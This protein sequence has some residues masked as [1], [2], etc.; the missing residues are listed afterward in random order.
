MVWF[1]F[2]FCLGCLS[3]AVIGTL[4]ASFLLYSFA[5]ILALFLRKLFLK[6]SYKP[7]N[8]Q[9]SASNNTQYERRY[10]YGIQ[11]FIRSYYDLW[12]R[13]IFRHT[14]DSGTKSDMNK[15]G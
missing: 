2:I 3:F 4:L 12:R 10:A 15:E 5:Y 7:L 13:D 8:E 6:D 14:G 9:N 11:N 1:W